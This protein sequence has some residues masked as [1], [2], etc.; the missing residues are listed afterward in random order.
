MI[1][2]RIKEGDSPKRAIIVILDETVMTINSAIIVKHK[3]YYHN[4][5]LLFCFFDKIKF[6][7]NVRK[8]IFFQ[9]KN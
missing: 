1:K 2:K 5:L 7:M 9:F 6:C 8:Y 3:R 4:R